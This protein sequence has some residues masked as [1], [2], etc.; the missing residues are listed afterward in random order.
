MLIKI[1]ARPA[2]AGSEAVMERQMAFCLGSGQLWGRRAPLSTIF[3]TENNHKIRN[4]SKNLVTLPYLYLL[5]KPISR[6]A[7][8]QFFR[9]GVEL[10]VRQTYAALGIGARWRAA[11]G[12]FTKMNPG[13][14]DEGV[15][16]LDGC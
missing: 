16:R 13:L 5:E 11:S 10:F 1:K 3:V 7:A 14:P 15:P 6:A 12:S 2:R 4:G 8:D 9:R